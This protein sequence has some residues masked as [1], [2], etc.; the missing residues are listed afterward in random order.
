MS[1]SKSFKKIFD[2]LLWQTSKASRAR[3]WYAA[4]K[5]DLKKVAALYVLIGTTLCMITVGVASSITSWALIFP[6]LGPTAMLIFYAPQSEMASPRNA[7]LSHLMSAAV[8]L[9]CFEMIKAALGGQIEMNP[10]GFAM[11]SAMTVSLGISGL[12]MVLFDLLHPPAASTALVGAM[13][14][15]AH[16]YDLP[17][18]MAA[19]LLLCSQGYLIH[20]LAG[21]KY[22]VWSRPRKGAAYR[23]DTDLT[24]FSSD[25]KESSPSPYGKIARNLVMRRRL[26]EL[27]GQ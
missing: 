14:M 19:L 7:L 22:P 2:L 15:F 20:K 17:V 18:M 24:L 5:M 12:L 10:P 21:V 27:N 1:V 3:F 13:G 26:E 6:G 11:I 25:E 4:T 23:I 8:G 16:W 9:F